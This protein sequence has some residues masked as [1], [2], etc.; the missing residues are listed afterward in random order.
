MHVVGVEVWTFELKNF[1]YQFI[2]GH[3]HHGMPWDAKVSLAP[4]QWTDVE[5]SLLKSPHYER[6]P[7][8]GCLIAFVTFLRTHP[9]D[10][11]LGSSG[12]TT[13]MEAHPQAWFSWVPQQRV[14]HEHPNHSFAPPKCFHTI[15][16]LYVPSNS[17]YVV[18][19]S[20]G[21]LTGQVGTLPHHESLEPPPKQDPKLFHLVH[22]GGYIGGWQW[23]VD[24]ADKTPG[25]NNTLR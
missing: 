10:Y 3:A 1:L 7:Q 17:S 4:H 19:Y 13:D 22:Q 11:Y 14:K 16:P 12:S 9:T 6:Q 25:V 23:W 15:R 24:V 8:R 20:S 21:A 18:S 2:D 5:C